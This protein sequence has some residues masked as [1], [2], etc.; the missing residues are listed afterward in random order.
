MNCCCVRSGHCLPYQ[1]LETQLP[2]DWVPVLE[3]L[4]KF[5]LSITQGPTITGTWASRECYCKELCAAHG[6]GLQ[7]LPLDAQ[8][9][10]P[11]NT[12]PPENTIGTC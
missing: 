5:I 12:Q 1:S 11:H 6:V 8:T 9:H 4:Y 3:S 10:K 2:I 7:D